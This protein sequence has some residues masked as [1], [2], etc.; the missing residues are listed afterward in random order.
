M[1]LCHYIIISVERLPVHLPFENNV[2]YSEDDNLEEVIQY[3]KN[4]TTKLTT[5]LQAIEDHPIAKQY[6]YIEFSE[7]F[8]WHLNGIYWDCHG[9]FQNKIGRIALV[10]P[11]Q[12][13]LC[14]CCF[15][16]SKDQLHLLKL[17]LPLAMNILHFVLHMRL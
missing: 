14:E 5:W 7:N 4:A 9:G 10:N 2:I 12:G 16:L 1:S 13:E 8:K 17:E 11:S 15:A 3:P 6:T